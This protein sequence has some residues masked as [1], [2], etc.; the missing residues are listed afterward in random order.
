M[1]TLKAT[2]TVSEYDVHISQVGKSGLSFDTGEN[3]EELKLA[4]HDMADELYKL[5]QAKN[6]EQA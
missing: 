5:Y 1:E 4:L 6:K 3:G 2:I